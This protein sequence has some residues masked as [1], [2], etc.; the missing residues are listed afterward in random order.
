[1]NK[2]GNFIKL[3]FIYLIII[4]ALAGC[5]QISEQN[6]NKIQVGMDMSQVNLILGPPTTTNSVNFFG[7]SAT[8]SVWKNQ[9]TEITILFVNNK[10]EIKGLKQ[11]QNKNVVQLPS[12]NL[13][14][15]NT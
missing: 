14:E 7:A 6:F 8:T 15:T 4:L 12:L 2:A 11:G 3:V 10:V 13:N 5:T 9:S 1:M